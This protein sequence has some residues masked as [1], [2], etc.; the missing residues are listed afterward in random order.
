MEDG[1]CI[2]QPAKEEIEN[3]IVYNWL[4]PPTFEIMWFL[5]NFI[6]S[7]NNFKISELRGF[8]LIEIYLT[9]LQQRYTGKKPQFGF[10]NTC[11]WILALGEIRE[12]P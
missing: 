4:S 10:E 9:Q 1:K 3:D 11:V 6:I 2:C 12:V 8:A 5:A 7:G